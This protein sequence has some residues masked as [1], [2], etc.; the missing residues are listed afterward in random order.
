M[1][2]LIDCLD[3]WTQAD[4]QRC[5][6]TFRDLSG[7]EVDKT[8][9]DSFQKQTNF[10]AA[11]L[12]EALGKQRG[13]RVIVSYPPGLEMIKAFVACVKLGAIPVPVPTISQSGGINDMA[14]LNSIVNDSG[15]TVVLTDQ[16]QQK[17]SVTF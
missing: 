6:F 12:I 15:A 7:R 8:S 14:R 3:H 1:N 4:P 17:I 5:L 9:Y 11:T 13:C 2:S 16:H 10:L